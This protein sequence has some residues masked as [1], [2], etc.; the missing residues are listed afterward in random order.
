MEPWMQEVLLPIV[1][2]AIAA[3]Y[4]GLTDIWGLPYDKAIQLTRERRRARDSE[5]GKCSGTGS[6]RRNRTGR[7]YRGDKYFAGNIAKAV[8]R[9]Y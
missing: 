7:L 4:S 1:L 6:N 9:V 8:R 2:A 3:L 5:N